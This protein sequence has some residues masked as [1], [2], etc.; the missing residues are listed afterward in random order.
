VGAERAYFPTTKYSIEQSDGVTTISDYVRLRTI[1]FFGVK[2]EIDVIPNFVNCNIYH[3]DPERRPARKR[4]MHISN[5]RPVKRVFDCI[6]ILASVRR[7]VDAELWMVGDGPLRNEAEALAYELGL[8]DYVEFLG[9][10]DHVERLFPQA[11]VVL[12]PSEL[13]A[14]GLAALEGQACGVPPVATDCGGVPELINHG[15]DGYLAPVG[16]IEAQA[17]YVVEMLSD[18]RLYE[19]VASAAR[20]NAESRFCASKIIPLYEGHYQRLC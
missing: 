12:M 9:K 5:F 10:Q 3:P 7:E 8:Q 14:F 4:L 17:A 1:E 20:H 15:V 18:D 11:H 13:E 6:R 16:D 2:H 19:R